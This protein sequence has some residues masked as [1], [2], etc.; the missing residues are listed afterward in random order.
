MPLNP[1]WR[2]RDVV[3]HMIGVCEDSLARNFP[4]F[5]DPKERP[6]QATAREAWTQEQVDRRRDCSIDELLQE[7]DRLARQWESVLRQ[8]PDDTGIDAAVRVAAPLDV[9]CHLHDLRH[10]LDEPGDRDA[11]I[12]AMAFAISRNWLGMRLDRAGL[13]AVRMRSTDREWVLGHRPVGVTVAGDRFDLFRAI[14]GRRSHEQLLALAWDDDPTMFLDALSPYP[15]PEQ[16]I[17]E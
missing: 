12:T 13:P 4:D 5:S 1:A 11:P 8:D 15:L 10:A 9:G 6:E 17:T 7:W 3:A 16:T 14:T 2:V